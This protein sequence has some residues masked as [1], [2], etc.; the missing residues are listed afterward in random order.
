MLS[1]L[2]EMLSALNKM[3]SALNEIGNLFLK[4]KNSIKHAL[5]TAL[6]LAWLCVPLAVPQHPVALVD[7]GC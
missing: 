4:Y 2:N 6:W 3:L 1:A 7:R 5:L